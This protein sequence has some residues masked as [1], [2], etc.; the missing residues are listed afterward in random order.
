M[1]AFTL[2]GS[3]WIYSISKFQMHHGNDQGAW[4]AETSVASVKYMNA[5]W[6]STEAFQI[7]KAPRQWPGGIEAIAFVALSSHPQ[8]RWHLATTSQYKESLSFV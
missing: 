3:P 1:M 5:L 7:S 2:F 6:I 8:P 4:S